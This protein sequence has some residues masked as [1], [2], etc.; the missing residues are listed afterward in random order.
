MRKRRRFTRKEAK[1]HRLIISINVI[2]I[3]CV[4]SVG[5][6]A[7]QTILN[8]NVNGNI[9]I[10]TECVEGKVWEF[11]Q[12]DEGQEFRV[13]CSGEY[14]VELWGAQGGKYNNSNRIIGKGSYVKGIITLAK[15]MPIYVYVGDYSLETSDSCNKPNN[16]SFNGSK[17]SSCVGG[18]G[19]TDIRIIRTENWYDFISLKS[20]I[21]V[22]G[23]GGGV[24]YIGSGGS[25]GGLTGYAGVGYSGEERHHVGLGGTQIESSFGKQG[26]VCTTLGGGGYYA[27]NGGPGG[28]AGGGSSFISGHGGCDAISEQST[29]D[30]IIHT[31]QSIHYSGLYFT[32][33]VMIDGEGYKWTD[34][35]LEDLGV[36]GMP[37]HDGTSTMTGNEGDGFAKITL[38]SRKPN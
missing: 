2:V 1:R 25:A 4:L 13:P 10:P 37:T 5:Y 22:A 29:E 14:K 11:S 28:N 3:I 18:G 32:D 9:K 33:T 35:K 21:I 19:A 24:F 27:G 12:K 31:G 26:A 7:F 34:H 17:Y 20:R 6:G 36:V 38:I 23:G 8:L 15:N 16:K 30:N